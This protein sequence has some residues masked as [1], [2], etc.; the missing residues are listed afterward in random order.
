MFHH[1]RV[2]N[3][4]VTIIMALLFSA[5]VNS[6]LSSA[7][8][9]SQLKLLERPRIIVT[10]DGEQDDKDSF[11][12][13]LLYTT[14]VDIEALIYTNSMWHPEG[15]GTRWM[16]DYIDVYEEVYENLIVHDE[17]F[18]RPDHLRS[19]LYVGEMKNIGREAVGEE[20]D[21]AG[22]G[23]I[24]EV[25]LDVDPRPV[26]LQ[27]WGGLNNI[28][29]ALYRIRESHPEQLDYA[30]SR[31]YIYAIAE[32]DDLR[33]WMVTEFPDVNYIINLHQFW[34]V[35]AYSHDRLNPF[36]DH[37]IYSEEWVTQ[38]I[39]SVGPLGGLYRARVQEEGD[40]PAF[41]HVINTGLRST[42]HPAWGGWGGRFERTGDSNLWIDAQDNGDNTKPLWRFIVPISEDFAARMQWT[43]TSDYNNANHPPVVRLTH[44]F[45]LEEAAGETLEL[46]ASESF[47]PDGDQL[48]FRWWQYVEAG[49]YG[50]V[51]EI[52]SPESDITTIIVPD[53]A[54]PGDII[55][56][57]CEVKDD[58]D[59]PMTR[60]AR[61]VIQVV[62]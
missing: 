60:Y 34:R 6:E 19:L 21:T 1:V 28:A 25:L 41:F 27:A 57:I 38:H 53:D 48:S 30:V 44:P 35:I 17:T 59:L 14:D 45:E 7:D 15:N 51:I 3:I 4:S 18:P 5:C 23:K 20:M 56:M 62:D 37:E 16:H 36:Q 46:N 47:D 2:F 32:Q 49:S 42:E 54:L 11:V 12:R 50:G 26:W 55:H 13:F 61:V 39:S 40:S 52:G 10:T 8:S 22:S 29:Q 9:N 43:V 58:A 33:E 24:V 31:A